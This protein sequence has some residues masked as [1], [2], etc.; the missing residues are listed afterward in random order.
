MPPDEVPSR[1]LVA[2]DECAPLL[3][4]WDGRTRA[5]SS[6]RTSTVHHILM[7]VRRSSMLL[8][9]FFVFFFAY[10]CIGGIV[11]G[12]L[13]QPVELQLHAEMRNTIDKFLFKFPT[14]PGARPHHFPLHFFLQGLDLYFFFAFSQNKNW[15][16]S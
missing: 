15:I 12:S 13:E 8:G 9:T 14:L 3:L 6:R 5:M 10:L 7:G 1:I 2:D 16:R 11:F 4:G